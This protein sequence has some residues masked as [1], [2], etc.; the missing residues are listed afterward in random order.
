M[1]SCPACGEWFS[2]KFAM[3]GHLRLS[4]DDRHVAYRGKKTSRKHVGVA[5]ANQP[6]QTDSALWETVS[7]LE[8]KL[9]TLNKPQQQPVTK[10]ETPVAS[11]N[12]SK[13]TVDDL[14]ERISQWETKL[15]AAVKANQQ[16]VKQLNPF[17]PM[18]QS[19]PAPPVI[20]PNPVQPAKSLTWQE[21]VQ[22]AKCKRAGPLD[23]DD[24]H[25]NNC[26]AKGYSVDLVIHL[27]GRRCVVDK[28]DDD[29]KD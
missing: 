20:Q 11:A 16:S 26:V 15:D 7:R 28:D 3:L 25:L 21:Y 12:L 4:N 23:F 5:S 18:I 1:P 6:K 2:L 14:L 13:Q 8:M 29:D 17:A 22:P 27:A 10:T 19:N 9:D 24:K